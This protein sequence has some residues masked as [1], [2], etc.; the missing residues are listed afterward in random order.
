M[1]M[2]GRDAIDAR[3]ALAS[4]PPLLKGY[5]RLGAVFGDGAVIDRKFN[6][7]D[8]FVVMPVKQID[9]RY[10]EHFGGGEKRAPRAA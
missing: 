8:V 9:A 7:V 6:T 4:L 10:L 5:L 1:E 3:R 2:L